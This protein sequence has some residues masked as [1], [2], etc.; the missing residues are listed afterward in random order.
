MSLYESH[1]TFPRE[2]GHQFFDVHLAQPGYVR[3]KGG[4]LW[5]LMSG[6]ETSARRVCTRASRRPGLPRRDDVPDHEREVLHRFR[7]QV[8][9]SDVLA[10]VRQGRDAPDDSPRSPPALV[11]GGS[12][13]RGRRPVVLCRRVSTPGRLIQEQVLRVL[14]RFGI[15]IVS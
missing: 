10:G 8:A 15:G 1:Q 7:H 13:T 2:P 11:W 14:F 5:P 9:A 6:D 3:A 12:L 4:G